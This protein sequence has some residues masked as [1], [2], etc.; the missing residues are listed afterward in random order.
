VSIGVVIKGAEGLVLAADSRV[1]LMAP[2]V[3]GSQ[4]PVSFDHAEKVMCFGDQR[5]G[6][7]HWYV[8]A[9]TYGLGGIGLRSIGSFMPELRGELDKQKERLPVCDFAQKLSDFFMKRWRKNMPDDFEGP[10]VTLVVAGFDEGEAYGRTYL[11]EV[12]NAPDPLEQ[13]PGQQFGITWGGQRD[14]VDRL[15]RGYD[16][17]LLDVAKQVLS[18]NDEQVTA[19]EEKLRPIALQLPMHIMPLQDC[20]DLALF[21]IR[22]TIEA[23]RLSAGIRGCGGAIDVAIITRTEGFKFVQKKTIRGERVTRAL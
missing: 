23:Q 6:D 17:R 20:V 1:T 11:V 10:G 7:G 3:D 18:L 2:A 14:V 8:G 16:V 19:L 12:P 21:F 13:H 4:I 15:L 22:T 9:V 5:N